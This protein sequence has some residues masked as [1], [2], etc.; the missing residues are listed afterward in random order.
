[1]SYVYIIDY[2]YFNNENQIKSNSDSINEQN[3]ANCGKNYLT[4]NPN[5]EMS[6]TYLFTNLPT[7]HAQR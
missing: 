5:F 4:E 7:A 3:D 6:L 1:M 2:E